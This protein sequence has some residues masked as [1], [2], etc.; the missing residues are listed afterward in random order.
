MRRGNVMFATV[1]Y[2]KS[3]RSKQAS[4]ST[5]SHGFLYNNT[6]LPQTP[7]LA[8]DIFP[9]NNNKPYPNISGH[10]ITE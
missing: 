4:S 1:P 6:C 9:H 7:R 3:R 2:T 5:S 10:W 8:I